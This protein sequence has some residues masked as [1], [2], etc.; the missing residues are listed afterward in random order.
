MTEYLSK[1][2]VR[3]HKGEIVPFEAEE[4]GGTLPLRALGF[5]TMLEVQKI[6]DDVERALEFIRQGIVD[7]ETGGPMFEVDEFLEV[8]DH[9]PVPLFKRL[10][11]RLKDLSGADEVELEKNSDEITK[12][13]S[14]IS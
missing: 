4:I 6:E 7:P 1:A 14:P 9:W 8:V 13:G 3:G 5:R 10:A 11:E 2:D 12:G